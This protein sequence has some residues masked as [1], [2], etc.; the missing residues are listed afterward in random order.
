MREK[1]AKGSPRNDRWAV[2]FPLHWNSQNPS[3]REKP[4]IN[5][6]LSLLEVPGTDSTPWLI[7]YLLFHRAQWT[8]DQLPK[9]GASIISYCQ[10]R[11]LLAPALSSARLSVF[12]GPKRRESGGGCGGE[13]PSR[14]H[15]G[16]PLNGFFHR[17]SALFWGSVVRRSGRA[18][19]PPD[20]CVSNETSPGSGVVIATGKADGHR[21]GFLRDGGHGGF[22][23][24]T[25]PAPLCCGHPFAGWKAA[26]ARL[27]DG[28]PARC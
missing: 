2:G 17:R 8:W 22:S 19:V 7:T 26:D 12:S 14:V 25:S 10:P 27:S 5:I 18:R 3:R 15:N 21:H 24:P 16:L 20:C 4:G 9:G 13:G 28:C 1:L 6:A 23:G 11:T